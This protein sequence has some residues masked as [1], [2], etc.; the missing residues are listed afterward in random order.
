MQRTKFLYFAQRGLAVGKCVQVSL[1]YHPP[2]RTTGQLFLHSWRHFLG[3][4]LSWLTMAILVFLSAMA[5][6]WNDGQEHLRSWTKN[7]RTSY[8]ADSSRKGLSNEEI[9]FRG[10]IKE[11]QRIKAHFKGTVKGDIWVLRPVSSVHSAEA[12]HFEQKKH[13][14]CSQQ[15]TYT[16]QL[17]QSWTSPC[18]LLSGQ[19]CLVFH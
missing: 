1:H 2:M 18:L 19:T 8:L 11:V 14:L 5:G 7:A 6:G 10:S 4:H 12:T 15:W 3:L 17:T 13:S 9:W 16:D